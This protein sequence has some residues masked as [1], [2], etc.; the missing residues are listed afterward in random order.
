MADGFIR[1]VL[2]SSLYFAERLVTRVS[3]LLCD[4]EVKLYP[5][6]STIGVKQPWR[7]PEGRYLGTHP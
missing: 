7:I 4:I 5:T 2:T 6:L 3:R 1:I